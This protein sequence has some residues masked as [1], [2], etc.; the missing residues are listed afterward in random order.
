MVFEQD[1]EC[2]AGQWLVDHRCGLDRG[3]AEWLE[4]L[5]PPQA[6]YLRTGPSLSGSADPTVRR[7]PGG[8]PGARRCEY[9]LCSLPD[10]TRLALYG[11]RRRDR[12]MKQHSVTGGL[13]GVT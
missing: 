5:D 13:G 2:D 1:A 6:L 12:E 8:L 11:D 10:V 4:R 9:R 7:P 3:E